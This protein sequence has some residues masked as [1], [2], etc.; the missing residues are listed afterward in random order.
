MLDAD[1]GLRFVQN[2]LGHANIQNTVITTITS[3][4]REAGALKCL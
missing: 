2:W 1:A 4:N 3:K